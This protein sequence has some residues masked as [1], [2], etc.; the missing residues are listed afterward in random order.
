M[1]RQ[2]RGGGGTRRG[3]GG[4]R[5][6]RG[7][8]GGRNGGELL[9]QVLTFGRLFIVTVLVVAV[10]LFFRAGFRALLRRRLFEV[11]NDILTLLLF[12][13]IPLHLQPPP[14]C[15]KVSSKSRNK[16][17]HRTVFERINVV[18]IAST[19]ATAEHDT[20]V[21]IPFKIPFP[22]H[23]V[24]PITTQ[25]TLYRRHIVRLLGVVTMLFLISC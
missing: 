20:A 1:E 11:A 7:G 12:L 2:R 3:G 14:T 17:Q 23:V 21:A 22:F 4:G 24:E 15:F 8:G 10:H 9:Q 18:H 19:A 5:R 13:A 16:N 25:E 6:R